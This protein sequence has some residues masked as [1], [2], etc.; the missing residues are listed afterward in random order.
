MNGWSGTVSLLAARRFAVEVRA[1][2]ERSRIPELK[3]STEF[4]EQDEE[5]IAA[6]L[7]LDRP[8]LTPARLG[9]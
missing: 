6:S 8:H 9:T 5:G 1:T 2:N 3:L 7:Y 4:A